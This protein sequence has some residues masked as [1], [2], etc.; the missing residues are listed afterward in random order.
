[1]EKTPSG[2][3]PCVHPEGMLYYRGEIE[4]MIY[5]RLQVLIFLTDANICDADVL[6][7]VAKIKQLI[8]AK[9]EKH[10]DHLETKVKFLEVVLERTV[11]NEK[12]LWQ[13]YIVQ[14]SSRHIFWLDEHSV[15]PNVYQGAASEEHIGEQSMIYSLN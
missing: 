12:K 4:L 10:K 11:D 3:R 8:I 14:R 9:I 5:G 7:E 13:Y 15:E 2:W 1:M 6:G